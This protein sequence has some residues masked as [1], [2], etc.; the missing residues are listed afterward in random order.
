[1]ERCVIAV[2]VGIAVVPEQQLAA[3]GLD[4]LV[5]RLETGG[6]TCIDIVE[7]AHEGPGPLPGLRAIALVIRAIGIEEIRMRLE[8]LAHFVPLPLHGFAMRRIDPVEVEQQAFQFHHRRCIARQVAGFAGAEI[9][10]SGRV[11]DGGR[12]PVRVNQRDKLFA[13][14]RV[15]EITHIEQFQPGAGHAPDPAAGEG[16]L[17]RTFTAGAHGRQR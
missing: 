3:L 6:A 17:D 15:Q 13:Q 10:V 12:A 5:N 8:F 4:D 7:I 11:S 14:L 16:T 2:P 9:I 1:M